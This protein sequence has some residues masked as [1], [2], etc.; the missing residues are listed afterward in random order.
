MDTKCFD[1]REDQAE[2][3]DSI[4]TL[5]Q[6]NEFRIQ[7]WDKR[8]STKI[9]HRLNQQIVY[10]NFA[11]ILGYIE[12]RADIGYAVLQSTPKPPKMRRRNGPTDQ[13]TDG[14]TD[15]QTLL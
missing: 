14:R 1:L 10:F 6:F 5:F 3:A 8:K 4:L 11:S 13:P 2:T 7:I 15:G 12:T 9:I